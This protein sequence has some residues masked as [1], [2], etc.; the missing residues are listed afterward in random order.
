MRRGR[1]RMATALRRLDQS[2][3]LLTAARLARELLPGDSR[4]GD[5]LS[6]AGAD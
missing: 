3:R 5:P 1:A 6:T 2:P 4:F